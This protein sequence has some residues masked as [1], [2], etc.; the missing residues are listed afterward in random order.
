MPAILPFYNVNDKEVN[1]LGMK[2]NQARQKDIAARWAYYDG[3]H[4]KPLK[5]RAGSK[6]DNVILNLCGRAIDKTTEFIGVPLRFEI[7]GDTEV[8]PG[9]GGQLQEQT[10]P[11]QIALDALW[12][13]CKDWTEEVLTSGQISGHVFLRIHENED[14]EW[15][16]SLL[17]PRTMT[18][19]WNAGIMRTVLFYRMEWQIGSQ[20]FRQ[21][22]VPLWLLQNDRANP[23]VLGDQRRDGSTSP[24]PEGWAIIE[25]EQNQRKEWVEIT[26][27]TWGFPFAPIVDWA[28]WRRPH[29]YYGASS[30]TNPGLN[31]SIN[32]VA[33]N[34]ARIIKYHAHPKTIGV[35]VDPEKIIPTAVDGFYSVPADSTVS[36][37]EMQSD[38]SSSMNMLTLLKGEFFASQRVIDIA[39][40]QDKLGQ[41]T[42]FG[43][44][45]MFS[46]MLSMTDELRKRYGSYG[47]SETLR[48]LLW[49]QGVQLEDRPQAS[50]DDPLPVNR[51]EILQTAK[52]ESELGTTSKQTLAKDLGRDYPTEQEHMDEETNTAG[53]AMAR[54]LTSAGNA[55][56]FA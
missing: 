26:R 12:N 30:L 3:D 20:A 36:N 40:V 16:Y 27:D 17:D 8:E 4:V 52:I 38:L 21:D 34:T 22:T 44:R 15:T 19:F 10:A 39:T 13:R 54:V 51:L 48:R 7:P 47:L 53:A 49:V 9:A 50:W 24:R 31:D 37:L 33:S 41:I 28:N 32:F 25:Y 45:M 18:V 14:A 55:G 56:A 1:D 2:E 6:D 5:V 35:G 46:D 29:Q 23:W 11:D 42:N 43:V